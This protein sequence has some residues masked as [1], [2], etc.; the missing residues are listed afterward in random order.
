MRKKKSVWERE[1]PPKNIKE[2]LKIIVALVIIKLLLLNHI[3]I[4]FHE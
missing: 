2:G 1:S 4:K 3:T